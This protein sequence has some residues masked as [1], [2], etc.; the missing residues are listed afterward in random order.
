MTP[1]PSADNQELEALNDKL[2]AT[3]MELVHCRAREEQYRQESQTLLAGLG[4][5][6]E[7]R[8]LDQVLDSLIRSLQPFIGFEQADVLA[9]DQGTGITHL[10]T[11]PGECG[12][13]WHRSPLFARA[14]AGETLV[15][16]DPGQLPEFAAV[17]GK[18]GWASLML[19]GL[20]APGFVGILLCR[21]SVR[22]G[23]DLQSKAALA[24]CRP[25]ISQALVNIAYRA[26]LQQQVAL[27][28]RE[29]QASELRFRR[30]AAMASDWFWETDADHRLSYVSAPGYQ[31]GVMAM[32][33][34]RSLYEIAH[35][36]EGEP[37]E[38][39]RHLVEGRQTI[40]AERVRI[41]TGGTVRW[42]EVSAEPSFDQ[43]GRFSGYSGTARDIGPQ[44]HRE[45]QLAQAR[46]QAE[47]AN[48][49][50]SQ[51]L[52]MM[53]HEIRSPM[54]A[55]MGML[56]LLQHE[57][58]APAQQSLLGHAAHSAR[59]L[60]TIIDDVLDFSKIEAHSLELH[61]E[62]FSPRSLCQ[63]IME[64][65]HAM[66]SGK[67]LTLYCELED[68]VPDALFGDPVRLSQ[69]VNNLLGNAVK[70]TERGR[71]VLRMGWDGQRLCIEVQDSGIGISEG[72]QARLFEPFTQVDSSATR[73]CAG[74]G[75]GL[76]IS[77]RL[78]TLMGGELCLASQL[79][80]GSRFWF[81]LPGLSLPCESE[82]RASPPKLTLRP[83]DVLVV[84]DS[85]VNQLVVSLMLQKL[86]SRVRLAGNGLEA[87]SQVA[88]QAPDL[89]LMDMRMPQMDGLEATRLLRELG[90]QMPIVALTA[91]A[92]AEDRARCLDGG[93]TDF[94]AKPISLA[95]LRDCL[96]RH[97]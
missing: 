71:V 48:R 81:S 9:W 31:G 58:L 91:N 11:E 13:G 88:E 92:M 74:T 79:G 52:A 33:T 53:T 76:S 96:A 26:R 16:Y 18:A 83:L 97:C 39:F 7:A 22:G 29:L 62:R 60:Q 47:A 55:V 37:W 8:T 87:I 38:K 51:F 73:H 90:Y 46:D 94:L 86:V 2:Q 63:A 24:R 84:E 56:D 64:P 95:R 54:N 75:L 19:T 77:K 25:L 32:E 5:L 42:M 45:Q 3:L 65:L 59:L 78:V 44:I 80:E 57:A 69:I 72:D 35:E 70:F 34:G 89:I 12:R 21:H 66:A 61:C 85:P 17:A 10:S 15:I 49:A 50:K 1:V 40:R 14:L 30:F 23:L 4:T 41:K 27:K 36:R 20:H 28:T 67:G 43:Q 93:M 68:A 6:A 82:A